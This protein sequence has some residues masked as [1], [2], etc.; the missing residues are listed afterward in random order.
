MRPIRLPSLFIHIA[1][2]FHRQQDQPTQPPLVVYAIRLQLHRRRGADVIE[3]LHKQMNGHSPNENVHG[4]DHSRYDSERIDAP[5]SNDQKQQK[6]DSDRKKKKTTTKVR[7]RQVAPYNPPL[8]KKQAPPRNGYLHLVKETAQFGEE[9]QRRNLLPSKNPMV[10]FQQFLANRQKEETPRYSADDS[11]EGGEWASNGLLKTFS[12]DANTM[13]PPSGGRRGASLN[14]KEMRTILVRGTNTRGSKSSNNGR[15]KQSAHPDGVNLR[16]QINLSSEKQSHDVTWTPPHN[17]LTHDRNVNGPTSRRSSHSSQLTI[18][19][20]LSSPNSRAEAGIGRGGQQHQHQVKFKQHYSPLPPSDAVE[21]TVFRQKRQKHLDSGRC[22]SRGNDN[23]SSSSSEEENSYTSREGSDVANLGDDDDHRGGTIGKRGRVNT[24]NLGPRIIILRK[25]KQQLSPPST[26]NKKV[27]PKKISPFKKFPVFEEEEE[28]DD[29]PHEG[30]PHGRS[31]NSSM[32]PEDFQPYEG[33][34][35]KNTHGARQR[36]LDLHPEFFQSH[37]HRRR[38]REDGRENELHKKSRG[39]RITFVSKKRKS[40]RQYSMVNP[41]LREGSRG[42]QEAKLSQ[43][44][45]RNNPFTHMG[46]QLDL[47]EAQRSGF[48]PLDDRYEEE[49]CQH[50]SGRIPHQQ[51]QQ[52]LLQQHQQQHQTKNN[53]NNGRAFKKRRRPLTQLNCVDQRGGDGGDYDSRYHSD[54]DSELRNSEEQ[55]QLDNNHEN[56]S[57]SSSFQGS[58]TEN[59][60]DNADDLGVD[61]NVSSLRDLPDDLSAT[62]I[63]EMG[64]PLGNMNWCDQTRDRQRKNQVLTF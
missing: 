27:S 58:E 14:T 16:S 30:S 39:E 44:E 11:E 42:L 9:R 24:G 46:E 8:G 62:E 50:G 33:G 35:S 59:H 54:Y 3:P 57:P 28:D 48:L 47:F 1:L 53:N 51:Q 31:V 32:E 52:Q 38:R 36:F 55:K 18:R 21:E 13:A 25:K 10:D 17:T 4:C 34:F 63:E 45:D 12:I 43:E 64:S 15:D 49:Q 23:S 19:S 2:I 26:S 40:K 29:D 22:R 5:T 60:D 6:Q 37:S 56:D 20:E 41:R 61:L 7:K